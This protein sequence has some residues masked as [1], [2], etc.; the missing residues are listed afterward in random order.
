MCVCVP[1]VLGARDRQ[2]L[3]TVFAL[4]NKYQPSDVTLAVSSQLHITMFN[5]CQGSLLAIQPSPYN[6]TQ[7]SNTTQLPVVLQVAC[8][9]LLQIIAVTAGSVCC[10]V[11]FED[12]PRQS[13]SQ[14]EQFIVYNLLT[15]QPD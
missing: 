7:I 6:K 14:G 13:V 8:F 9:R 12:F 4:S 1:D 2:Q 15:V 3:L 10:Y 11:L 5:M